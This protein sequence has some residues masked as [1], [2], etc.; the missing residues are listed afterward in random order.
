VLLFG[1]TEIYLTLLAGLTAAFVATV[2][3]ARGP[4]VWY[5]LLLV[6]WVAV[7]GNTFDVGENYRFRFMVDPIWF[8][9][10]AAL[11]RRA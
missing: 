8:A 5:S 7:M 4:E 6:A 9:L 10:A 11:A 3:R 1:Q 2:M